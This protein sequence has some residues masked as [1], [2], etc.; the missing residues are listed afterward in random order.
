VSE[1]G[2]P[3]NIRIPAKPE[4]VG[5]VRL[6]VAAYAASLGFDSETA[7]DI[8]IAV[9]EACTSAIMQLHKE[10]HP[11]DRF[12]GISTYTQNGD[13][14]IDVGFKAKEATSI[15]KI[16][17]WFS[18]RDLGMSILTSIMDDVE[19]AKAENNSVVIKLLKKVE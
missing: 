14:V 7:E 18:E 1:F 8:K 16:Q 15:E 17:T 10:A 19:I 2:Q 4:Y 5:T 6:V 11:E 3:T 12:V 9:S 13:L